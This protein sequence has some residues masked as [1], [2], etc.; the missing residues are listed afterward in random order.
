MKK[1]EGIYYPAPLPEEQ[2]GPL[3]TKMLVPV[4]YKA[5]KKKVE[6]KAKETRGG[7]RHRDTLDKVSEDSEARSSSEEDEEKEKIQSPPARGRKKRT[8]S[9][10]LEAKSSK[11]GKASSVDDSTTATNSSPEWDPRVQSLVRS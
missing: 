11:R 3:L 8:A 7:L 6:K 9:K 5:P 10:P 4:P 2:S 1:A